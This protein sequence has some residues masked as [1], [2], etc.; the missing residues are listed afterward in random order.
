VAAQQG[1]RARAEVHDAGFLPCRSRGSGQSAQAE[2]P[3]LV[4]VDLVFERAERLRHLAAA[5]VG[6]S[7]A[8]SWRCPV[9]KPE[10]LPRLAAAKSQPYYVY[11]SPTDFIPLAQAEAARDTLRKAGAVVELQTYEGGHGWQGNVFRDIRKGIEWLEKQV[12]KKAP[13]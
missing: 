1:G 7:R 5:E 4:H 10:T 12:E 13:R 11:H 8:P 6:K 2:P 3:L 9:F